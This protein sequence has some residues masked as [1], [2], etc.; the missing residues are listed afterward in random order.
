VSRSAGAWARVRVRLTRTLIVVIAMVSVLTAAGWIAARTAPGWYA[1]PL[2][3]EPLREL[4]EGVER[5]VLS[6]VSD[7]HPSGQPW[8]L[9]VTDRE[10]SA[11]MNVRLALWAANQRIDLPEGL[12]RWCARF[13]GGWARLGAAWSGAER[14]WV[15]SAMIGDSPAAGPTALKLGLLPVPRWVAGRFG[16]PPDGRAVPRFG[17]GDG[18]HVRVERLAASEGSLTVTLVTEAAA[19]AS[20]RR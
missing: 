14:E 11:W 8:T 10:A 3:D 1:P 4:A 20:V 7:V 12:A 19:P 13:E 15:V 5:R 2:I 16:T 18:R 6:E 9:T 17:L